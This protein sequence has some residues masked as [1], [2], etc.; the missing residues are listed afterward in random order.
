MEKKSR[1]DEIKEQIANG[2]VPSPKSQPEPAIINGKFKP[3][4]KSNVLTYL[5]VVVVLIMGGVILYFYTGG[6]L[7]DDSIVHRSCDFLEMDGLSV[8]RCKDGTYWDVKRREVQGNTTLSPPLAVTELPLVIVTEQPVQEE[9][10]QSVEIPLSNEQGIIG[11]IETIKYS[12]YDPALGGTNCSNF[13]NGICI[14]HTAS[15]KDWYPL[16]DIACACPPEW[17]FG[18]L[19]ILD[20]Q[21]WVCEDRGGAIK[22]DYQGNTYVDF[23][24]QNPTHN[25]GEYVDVELVFPQN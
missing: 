18:T 21:Q 10:V 11:I 14:S 13:Q 15:G 24:T 12:R 9:I 17:P 1:L 23:L 25:Y 7:F 3:E 20:G 19:V 8:A 16:M 6:S 5:L 2:K 4:R 22:Y